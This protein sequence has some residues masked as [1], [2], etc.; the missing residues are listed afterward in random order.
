MVAYCDVKLILDHSKIH[1]LNLTDVDSNLKSTF[2]SLLTDWLAVVQV[3]ENI[4]AVL[5]WSFF[6]ARVEISQEQKPRSILGLG[7]R[8]VRVT[9]GVEILQYY[10]AYS[11]RIHSALLLELK[12]HCLLPAIQEQTPSHPKAKAKMLVVSYTQTTVNVF[13]LGYKGILRRKGYSLANLQ[14]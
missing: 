8:H 14:A 10:L 7:S 3:C 4:V 5:G 2:S 9:I 6:D 11:S 13:L 12:W 1:P